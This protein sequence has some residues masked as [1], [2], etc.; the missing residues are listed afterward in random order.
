MQPHLVTNQKLVRNLMLVMSLLILG[1]G[2]L[3]DIM[4]LLLEVL[5]PFKKFGFSVYLGLIMG[6]LHW[7]RWNEHSYING[8]QWLEPQAHRKRVVSNGVVE[9]F[10]IAMLNIWNT[11]IHV[12]GFLELYIHRI[13]TIIMFTTSVVLLFGDERKSIL[14]RLVSIRDYRLDQKVLR[15]LLSLSE[16]MVCVNPK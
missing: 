6:G 9:G 15:N 3:Q 8:G 5:D 14:V 1:I 12:S 4:N 10:V 13:C 16:I 7:G 2:L 11:L